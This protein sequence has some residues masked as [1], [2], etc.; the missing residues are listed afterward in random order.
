MQQGW[1]KER[2]ALKQKYEQQKQV[3]PDEAWAAEKADLQLKLDEAEIEKQKLTRGWEE[4]R[5]TLAGVVGELRKEIDKLRRLQ[6]QEL[7]H[8]Q[9]RKGEEVLKQEKHALEV[10]VKQLQVRC[11]EAEQEA[12][13]FK[14]EAIRYTDL[15]EQLKK[16][17]AEAKEAAARQATEKDGFKS[18]LKSA[19][20]RLQAE[21]ETANQIA[22]QHATEMG[23]LK[24]TQEALEQG[25]RERAALGNTVELLGLR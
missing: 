12:E 22:A 25:R 15:I 10:E 20:Q 7:R 6:E 19:I 5:A 3:G 16:E 18:T 2:A 24:E 17:A 13:W 21:R 1:D 14:V 8:E 23:I 9:S 11:K 4:E